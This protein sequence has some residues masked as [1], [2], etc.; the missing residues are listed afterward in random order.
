MNHKKLLALYG[1]Q[2]NPFAAD[3]PHEALISNPHIDQFLWKVEN[4]VIDGGFGLVTGDPGLGKSVILRMLERRLS[5]LKDVVVAEISRPH[6]SIA[7]FYRELG[8]LFNIE[9]KASNRYGGFK[10]LREQWCSHIEQTLFRPVILI[11]EAQDMPEATL[12][13]IRL[14]ASMKLDSQTVLAVVLAADLRFPHRLQ[15][16]QLLPLAS[17]IRA[18]LS[19]E[20]LSA[21]QLLAMLEEA[22]SR[23]GAPSLMTKPLMLAIAEAAAGNPRRMNHIAHEILMLGMLKE[24]ISLDEQLLFE[25]FPQI[26][27]PKQKRKP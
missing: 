9:L 23:A 12:A 19:L 24:A 13:E 5:E 16:P 4:L 8:A 26:T 20:R 10:K 7:D 21:Q 27:Q 22:T 17:R 3:I 15:S 18:R 6:S 11:D 14:L 1:L 2:W 25:A